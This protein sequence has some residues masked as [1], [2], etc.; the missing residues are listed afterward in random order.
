[1]HCSF[2]A[3]ALPSRS[4]HGSHAGQKA[5][6]IIS[7]GREA[8]DAA[9]RAKELGFY[10]I[11]ADRDSEAP[12]FA[13]T[14]SIL[15]A[16]AD[17]AD[18]TSAAAERFSRKI[19]RIDGAISM[20]TNAPMT[21]AAVARPARTGRSFRTHLATRLRQARDEADASRGGPSGSLVCARRKRPR[22]LHGL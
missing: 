19:R 7:G 8:A 5:L 14:D 17:G 22:R 12:A 6:L 11:V 3:Q 21:V 1:M 13:I 10:V 15:I 20:A 2:R 16:D 4:H 18:E 9:R